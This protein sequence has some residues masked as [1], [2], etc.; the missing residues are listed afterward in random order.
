MDSEEFHTNQISET[1]SEL[2]QCRDDERT[3]QDQIL[4]ICGTGGTFLAAIFGLSFLDNLGENFTINK[5]LLFHTSNII[6]FVMIGHMVSLGIVSGVRFHYMRYLEDRLCKLINENDGEQGLLHWMSLISTITTRNIRHLS[7]FPAKVHYFYS[8]LAAICAII[9]CVVITIF[10][11]VNLEQHSLLDN[12]GFVLLSLFSILAS[13]AFF[14]GNLNANKMYAFAAKLGHERRTDRLHNMVDVQL[15]IVT[16]QGTAGDTLS[17][18]TFTTQNAPSHNLHCA[19]NQNRSIH[20]ISL[21]KALLYYIYPKTQDLQKP[22]LIVL[23]FVTGTLFNEKPFIQWPKLAIAVIMIDYLIYQAR[24]QW[25]DIRGLYE[26]MK[27]EKKNR[28]PFWF[29]GIKKAVNLSLI[30]IALRLFSFLV[31]LFRINVEIRFQ[32]F[33]CA[34]LV[35]I[36]AILYEYARSNHKVFPVFFL[37]SLGYPLRF[38]VGLLVAFPNFF[39]DEGRLICTVLLLISYALMGEFSVLITWTLEAVSQKKSGKQITKRHYEYLYCI[40]EDRGFNPMTNN[41]KIFDPWNLSFLASEIVLFVAGARF[42]F[43]LIF[44]DLTLILCLFLLCLSSRKCSYIK[45]ILSLGLF[46]LKA[47]YGLLHIK[48]DILYLY[49]LITQFFFLSI[50][51]FSRFFMDPDFDLTAYC[52]VLMRKLFILLIGRKTWELL[53]RAEEQQQE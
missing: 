46:S 26:D 38:F 12:L 25:N 50:Y 14:T 2:E 20:L 18:E 28:L 3:W 17:S 21:L 9:F 23:G 30:V 22:I 16:S 44:I 11:Y 4:Q 42:D 35:I 41:G 13:G 36:I 37:V 51:Y 24:F 48:N 19:N 40:V 34:T 52:K 31:L 6:F 45:L 27:A 33:A 10:Q 47:M 39:C 43:R 49:I 32:I 8:S 7:S 29:F 1:I 53:S 5:S 15:D